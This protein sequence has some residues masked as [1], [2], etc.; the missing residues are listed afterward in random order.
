MVTDRQVRLL[1]ELDRKGER[2]E[3]SAAKAGMDEKTARK[4]RR[5]GRLPSQVRAPHVWRTREDPFMEIWEE[6]RGMLGLLPGLEVKTLFEYFRRG[7]PG[8][9]SDGQLR[10]PTAGQAVAGPGR[11]GSGGLFPP[12]SSSG[13][14][15]RIG[16][17]VHELARRDHQPSVLRSSALPLRADVLDWEAGTICF[18]ES[19]ESLSQGLQD[20]LWKLGGPSGP[21]HGCDGCCR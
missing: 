1:M 2:L 20:A 6:A 16:L 8:R 7:D 11:A 19:F 21:N 10:T 12:G 13:G 15:Q 17:H 14:Y 5:L 3:T 9:F 18:S 4:Y